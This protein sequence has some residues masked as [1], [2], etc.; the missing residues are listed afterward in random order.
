MLR[1]KVVNRAP[2]LSQKRY[3]LIFR[4][5]SKTGKKIPTGHNLAGCFFTRQWTF[6]MFVLLA[7]V[8]QDEFKTKTLGTCLD[9]P[10]LH[11]G[12][13]QGKDTFCGITFDVASEKA[14]SEVKMWTV[15]RK[16][17]LICM[18]QSSWQKAAEKK[19]R[20]LLLLRVIA[21]PVV[22]ALWEFT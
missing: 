6:M 2:V 5:T 7:I 11:C 1:L 4:H 18:D 3:P 21:L 10:W 8:K 12:L 20:S 15:L 19:N 13:W 22:T 16:I 14:P 9:F 17:A